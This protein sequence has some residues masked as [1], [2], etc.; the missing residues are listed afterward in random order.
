VNGSYINCNST[1]AG[2][3]GT[4][5]LAGITVNAGGSFDYVGTGTITLTGNVSNGGIVR[6]NG[7]GRTNGVPDCNGTQVLITATLAHTWSVTG[8][9]RYYIEDVNVVDQVASPAITV[10]GHL[11]QG[12]GS[13][14]W[15]QASP[16]CPTGGAD[17]TAVSFHSF[18]AIPQDGGVLLEWRTGYE[19]SNLGFHIYREDHGRRVRVTSSS[20]VAGSALLAG[21]NTRLTAGNSYSWF[22]PEGTSS[23]TYTIED[24]DLSGI[25]AVR[26]PFDVDAAAT[27]TSNVRR[28]AGSSLMRAGAA[29]AETASRTISQLGRA[30][31]GDGRWFSTSAVDVAA[32]QATDSQT[33]RQYALARGQAIEVAAAAQATNSQTS[34][35][36]ALAGGQAVKLGV[37]QEGWY[38]VDAGQLTAAGM[39]AFVNPDTL[40][41]FVNGKEQDILVS[42]QRGRVSA[43]EFYGT[44]VDTTWS[45][46]QVYWL[47]W[48]SH[49]GQRIQSQSGKGKG[50]APTSFPFTV[51]WKPRMMYFPA[52]INGDAD[53]FFG[54]TLDPTEPVTQ[55]LPV[56]NL[57]AGTPGNSTLQIKMQGVS[58]GTH[59]VDVQLNGN[60]LGSVIFQ[61][62]ESGV[63]SFAVSNA[64]LA[65]GATLTLTAHGD[66]SDVTLV[67]TVALTYPHKYAADSDAL[68]FT[69]P[70]GPQVMITGFSNSQIQVMDVTD[71][72]NVTAP[73]GM[74]APQRG[75]GYAITVVPQGGG[76]RTLL[77]FTNAQMNLPAN[78]EANQP[79]SWHSAQAGADMV[80]I[81][82]GDFIDSLAQLITLRQSQGLKV[83]VVNVEDLYDEFNY[84][85]LSPYAVK[86]FLAN[87]RTVWTRKPRWVLLVGDATSDPRDYFGKHQ[88]DYVPVELVATTQLETASDDWFGDFNNDGIPEMAFGRL[89][90]HAVSDAAALVAKIVAY[91][92]AVAAPWKNK[93]LLAAGANDSENNFESYIAAVQALLPGM[94]VTKILQGSD[95]NAAAD[96]L[97]A[98]N[99]GQ[100]LVDF[101][102]H[103]ATEVWLGN[104]FSS[105]AAGTV[106]NG[107]ATPFLISMTCLNGY[108]QDVWT[109]SLAE[110]VLEAPGGG[111]VGVWASSG[112]TDSAPQ[113]TLN[114]AMIKALYGGGSITVGEAA[115]TA[116]KAV[117]DPDVRK[118]WI[119]FGDPAM[120]IK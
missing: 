85:V 65:E 29:R 49:L 4:L 76:T 17:P 64:S 25:K 33:G 63:S 78:V 62:Q 98:F 96:F 10:Y 45:D 30:G 106:T 50:T 61:D 46:T 93:A 101:S 100:G 20:P 56:A 35:Q 75:G 57:S 5:S 60:S 3:T 67:D 120:K 14:G 87:A 117:T 52:L 94:T 47:T 39:P 32:A 86:N 40:Q 77:A 115:V 73:Q 111:A 110:A 71:P 66:G 51:Q 59:V 84:G 92:K 112:L 48:G 23:S 80:I 113:A 103:G 44:G 72:A 95:P 28:A 9:G 2:G 116:K 53:N 41:L 102:G 22:D 34:Q 109:F 105:A 89:P 43:V 24:L 26:G 55:L 97:A 19:V 90:V 74:V 108:F 104:L 79:S 6:I 15:T 107:A 70:S 21:A 12:T 119:L 88:E 83:A 91:D 38:H 69:A 82:H 27:L 81:S 1:S 118:T 68:R 18:S 8:S 36:Y 11:T 16:A 31:S 114:Q 99:S 37:R 42:E 58:A 7:G 13:S 54:P